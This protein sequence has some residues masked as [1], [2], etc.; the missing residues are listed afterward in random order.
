MGLEL[1]MH[2]LGTRKLGHL[3]VG[4]ETTIAETFQMPWT[5]NLSPL[6]KRARNDI[7]DVE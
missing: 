4:A 6:K 2:S 7:C 1:S 3:G 5:S